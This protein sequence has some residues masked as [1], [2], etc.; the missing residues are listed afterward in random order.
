M[1]FRRQRAAAKHAPSNICSQTVMGKVRIIAG[2]WRR[3]RLE[4][5]DREALRPTADRVRETLFNWL[6]TALPGARCLDLFAGTGVL[7]IEAVSRGAEHAVLVERDPELAGVLRKQVGNLQADNIEVVHA[8]AG[9][10]LAANQARFDIVF[11]D[12]PFGERSLPAVC[13]QL[14][15]ADCLAP[16]A[17][18]YLEGDRALVAQDLPPGWRLLRQEKAGQVRYHLAHKDASQ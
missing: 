16:G 13:R 14:Q 7:G 10:W 11:V 1:N 5:P 8:D 17:R 15:A 3:R 6:Q 4:F 18:I 2:K 12:P 9:N